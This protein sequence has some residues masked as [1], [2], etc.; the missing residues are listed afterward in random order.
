MDRDNNWE[1]DGY[2]DCDSFWLDMRHL[3]TIEWEIYRGIDW[4]INRKLTEAL[5][6]ALTKTLIAAL[7]ETSAAY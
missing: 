1:I 2:A 6:K 5:A 7:S 3:P 4:D